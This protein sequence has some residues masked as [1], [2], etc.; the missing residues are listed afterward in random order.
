MRSGTR[1]SAGHARVLFRVRFVDRAGDSAERDLLIEGVGLG[2]LGLHRLAAPEL[3]E[4]FSPTVL[5]I[6]DG[7]LY[8]EWLPDEERLG[9]VRCADEEDI[10]ATIAGYVSDRRRALPL[11]EDLGLRMAGEQPAWEVASK[12]LSRAFGRAWPPAQLLLT[13]RAAKR[14][15]RVRRPSVI[16]GNTDL[17]QWFRRTGSPSSLVKPDVGEDRHSNL[18]AACFD[19]VFDLAG[20]TARARTP[21]LP[22]R[23][24]RAFAVLTDEAADEE[25]WLLYE[26]V[27]LWGRER[28]QPSEGPELRR[29]RARALQRYFADVYLRDVPRDNDGPLCALDIDGVLEIDQL[30]FPGL[31][32]ASALALRSLL[33][34]GYRPLLASGRSLGEVSER[35]RAYGLAGGVAE[36]GAVTFET[37]SGRIE[38]LVSGSGAGALDRLRAAL[39]RFDGVCLDNDYRFSVR[40]FVLE[41]GRRR[42]LPDRV[43]AYALDRVGGPGIRPVAGEGQTDFVAPG[44]SKEAG[45]RVLAATLGASGRRPFVL[46]VGDSA[47]DAGLLGI[48]ARACAPRHAHSALGRAGF[49]LM[50]RPYQAGLAQ[51]VSGLLGHPPGGCP[52][53]QMPPASRERAILASLLG[54][55]ERGRLGIVMRAVELLW[56]IR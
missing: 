28:S 49:E 14:V 27:H 53:C 3:V 47:A 10:A 35:C 6:R 36:Y 4:Q 8:R 39:G 31:T 20:V 37:A 1:R 45:L 40:A 21:S 19:A 22:R 34:H 5:G 42:R 15:L 17:W 11:E 24:R 32:P 26:L 54:L 56:R 46:A 12:I 52:I 33:V 48:A 51:A 41:D 16:D 13:N 43:V 2:Y 30:G 29:A 7:L 23:L 18:T 38:E 9:P 55:G 25:R 50:T 44:V